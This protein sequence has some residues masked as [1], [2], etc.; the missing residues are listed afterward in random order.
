MS[1]NIFQ[2]RLVA[3]MGKYHLNQAGLL[4]KCEHIYNSKG[5]AKITRQDINKYV[6]GKAVPRQA[7][8]SI[9]AEALDISRIWLSGENCSDIPGTEAEET[10]GKE[11][12][13]VCSYA[14]SNGKVGDAYC[15]SLGEGGI[16]AAVI[17]PIRMDVSAKAI[18]A[19]RDAAELIS[20]GDDIDLLRNIFDVIRRKDIDYEILHRLFGN[21]KK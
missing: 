10:I 4:E 20:V 3:M 19:A 21:E 18:Q 9:L 6:N 7:K 11:L 14:A 2:R 17:V 1:E 5:G 15:W 12:H 16:Y 13:H 8:L